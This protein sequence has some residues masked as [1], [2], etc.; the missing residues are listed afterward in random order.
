MT[1]VDCPAG[2]NLGGA[3]RPIVPDALRRATAAPSIN[4][5]VAAN[6]LLMLVALFSGA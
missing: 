4:A 2:A 3:A 5:R 1:C 6:P